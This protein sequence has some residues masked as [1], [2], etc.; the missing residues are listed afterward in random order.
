MKKL[1]SLSLSL[2]LLALIFITSCGTDDTAKTPVKEMTAEE[3]S[4]K[5]VS[6]G[7]TAAD[8]V[9]T[10]VDSEGV[11]AL[12][13]LADLFEDFDQ[14]SSRAEQQSWVK[15][16]FQTISHY[17]VHGPA[18][19][20]NEDDFSFD[21]IKGVHTWNFDLEAFER[22]D[23][24]EFFVVNFPSEGSDTN[25]A[26]LKIT[27][28]QFVTITTTDE[29]DTY[30]DD[31]PTVI[32]GTLKVDGETYISLSA[33]ADWSSEGIPEKASVDLLVAPFTLL[34]DFDDTNALTSSGSASLK[35]N[36]TTLMAVDLDITFKTADKE[37][38]TD[39]E[40]FVQY[41]NIKLSGSVDVAGYEENAYDEN[42]DFIEGFDGNEYIDL[43]VLIDDVKVGDISIVNDI[44]YIVYLDGTEEVLEE[45]LEDVIADIEDKF[46]EFDSEDDDPIND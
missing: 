46:E 36:G 3:A 28:L 19:R 33:S 38:P 34:M 5:I 37:E 8:D 4:A 23:D 12:L 7:K 9:V 25:N 16:K 40:G 13:A 39:I 2:S 45:L 26:E 31:Y 21:N 24:S 11:T 27:D 14:F 30:E 35:K 44:L 15:A 17:F 42:D 6:T 10:M 43:E 41:S 22:T 32:E 18:Q 1:I 29:W 20:V